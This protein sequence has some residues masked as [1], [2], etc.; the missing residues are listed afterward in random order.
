MKKATLVL[1]VLVS[2]LAAAA[3]FADARFVDPAG[4]SGAAPDITAVTAAHDAA[5][6]LT[7]T[8]TTNRTTLPDQS[9]LTLFFDTD[10]SSSTGGDGVERYLIYGGTGGIFFRWNGTRFVEADA[11]SE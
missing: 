2:L 4:D 5:G 6:N 1:V 3:A 10:G 7:L 8:V 11:P 9:V